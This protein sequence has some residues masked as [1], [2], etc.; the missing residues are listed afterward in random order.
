MNDDGIGSGT[1][2]ARA[3]TV[4]R[5]A[6]WLWLPC[7]AAHAAAAAPFDAAKGQVDP[8]AAELAVTFEGAVPAGFYVYDRSFRQLDPSEVTAA[9]TNLGAGAIEG[10]S[11]LRVGG[12]SAYVLMDLRPYAARFAGR[13]VRFTAWQRAR[14]TRAGLSVNWYVGDTD[15]LFSTGGEGLFEIGQ[16]PFQETGRET[17]DGWVE[18]STGPVDFD[19]AHALP[20]TAITIFDAQLRSGFGRPDAN[21]AVEL[22][23]LTIEIDGPAAVPDAACTALDEAMRC[24]EAGL[25]AYGRCADAAARLGGRIDAPGPRSDYV[26]RRVFEL[27]TFVGGRYSLE[28]ARRLTALLAPERTGG[29]ARSWATAWSQIT[30]LLGDG[31]FSRSIPSFL[32]NTFRAGACLYLSDAD[33]L[34]ESPVAPMVF[35]VVGPSVGGSPGLLSGRVQPGDVLVALDGLPV[36]EW[37]ARTPRLVAFAGDPRAAEVLA[38]PDLIDAALA[39]G[40]VATFARCPQGKSSAPSPC[41]PGE[42]SRF[43]VSLTALAAPLWANTPPGGGGAD[44]TCDFRFV[45]PTSAP[46]AGRAYEYAGVAER[47][48]VRILQINGVPSPAQETAWGDTV[49]QFF[50]NTS[51]RA[52]L[53]HRTG[54]GGTIDSVDFIASHWLGA[55]EFASME[56][57]PALEGP[58][59]AEAR[60]AMLA[61]NQSGTSAS[62]CA[63]MFEWVLGRQSQIAPAGGRGVAA[64]Q[65]LAILSGDDVSGNDF[66]SQLLT[67]RA[68]PTRF[69]GQAPTRGAF[70]VIWSL[71]AYGAEYAGGSFQVHDTIFRPDEAS[72]F[73]EDF[74]TARGVPPTEVVRQRQSD[75][76][77]GLDTVLEAAI[78]WAR[79]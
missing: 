60:R 2:L 26:D 22:D 32:N 52:I 33:L 62:S 21:L 69:F 23:A 13:R 14:G 8:S 68:A 51:T 15:T 72:V 25:C 7:I 10:R 4:K 35:E 71:P 6:R 50:A 34:P 30:N 49:A 42:V 40:A 77:R 57:Y 66:L 55:D 59:S 41:A 16:L 39:T 31:H 18:L 29:T 54:G 76:L 56:L 1:R 48:G 64:G 44:L 17:D 75:L 27:T 12:M 19:F 20:A 79:Q 73:V 61:C 58:V 3:R 36:Q 46:G 53:D 11:A 5:L 74:R 45:S 47:D 38:T 78:S 37:R 28:Q 63:N 70:G 67:Y 24:G 65:R 9:L 43:D